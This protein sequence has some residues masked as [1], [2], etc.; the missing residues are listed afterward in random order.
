MGKFVNCN[1][2]SVSLRN[3]LEWLINL[4]SNLSTLTL[5][6]KKKIFHERSEGILY[7]N[8]YNKQ[9]NTKVDIQN[10]RI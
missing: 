2:T 4:H 8:I 7:T 5:K 6:E 1:A 3:S 9:K 10:K